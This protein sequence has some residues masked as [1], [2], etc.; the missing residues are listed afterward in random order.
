MSEVAEAASQQARDLLIQNWLKAKEVFAKAQEEERRL[1]ALVVEDMFPNATKGTN[2]F[3][4]GKGYALKYVRTIDYVL[5]DKELCVDGVKVKVAD[6]VD[7][8]LERIEALGG[9]GPALAARVVK[10]TPELSPT[11]YLALDVN[12]PVQ[13]KVKEM[14]DQMLTTKDGSP[15]LTFEVPKE[16]GGK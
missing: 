8:L 11:E 16:S 2:R 6:Q 7:E 13:E 14:I 3:Q 10:W 1:R 12:F 4:L 9:E 5:G 15:Q